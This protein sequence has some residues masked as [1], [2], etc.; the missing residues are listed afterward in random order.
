M[1]GKKRGR[2][3]RGQPAHGNGSQPPSFPPQP[4]GYMPP[5]GGPSIN[6]AQPRDH[7]PPQPIRLDR[8]LY[9]MPQRIDPRS[10]LPTPDFGSRLFP[11]GLVGGDPGL[12][13]PQQP[14]K[15]LQ[16]SFVGLTDAKK[17]PKVFQAM[18]SRHRILSWP[19]TPLED[20]LMF[21]PLSLLAFGDHIP[22]RLITS[23]E[24]TL[25]CPT[26]NV[27]DFRMNIQ[28]LLATTPMHILLCPLPRHFNSHLRLF[29]PPSG[30]LRRDSCLPLS[31]VHSLDRSDQDL[32]S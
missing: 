20:T 18:T 17:S 22:L 6:S 1:G 21:P 15:Y 8:R 10:M 19:A 13:P 23:P 11:Q 4:N 32:V 3:N 24:D 5:F 29:R 26:P 14:R 30:T 2:R 25:T 16:C 27:L 9:D 12:L 28:K 7:Y 31:T